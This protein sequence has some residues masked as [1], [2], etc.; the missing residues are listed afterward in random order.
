MK[1]GTS[2]SFLLS[3]ATCSETCN[4]TD[5]GFGRKNKTRQGDRRQQLNGCRFSTEELDL[6]NSVGI[7]AVPGDMTQVLELQLQRR[8]FSG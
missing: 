2:P 6:F 4:V 7:L 5:K 1:Y 3:P 8:H